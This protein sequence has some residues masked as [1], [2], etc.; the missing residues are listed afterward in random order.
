[1]IDRKGAFHAD[2]LDTL[3]NRIVNLEYPPGMTLSDKELGQEFGV[4][5]T[6]LRE[7]LRKLKEMGL[8]TILPRYGTHV[9]VVDIHDIRCAFDV[10]LKL[11]GLAGAA[12]ARRIT[13]DS[14]ED[15]HSLVKGLDVLNQSGEHEPLAKMALDARFHKIVYKAAENHILYD[16]LDN[17]YGRCARAWNASLGGVDPLTENI[18]QLRGIYLALK[19]RDAAEAARLCEEH[20]QSFI[21]KLK[22]YLL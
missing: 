14:L 15:L 10:R 16:F 11:E 17:L 5:R 9:S 3:R 4:S 1:M 8:V 20:V 6:P 18:E 2:L 13:S 12:A 22:N 19:R 7:V 21:L